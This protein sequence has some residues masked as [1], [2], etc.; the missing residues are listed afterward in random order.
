MQRHAGVM[1]VSPKE[2]RFHKP[3]SGGS[4]AERNIEIDICRGDKFI[5]GDEF[6]GLVRHG[7]RAPGPITTP[8]APSERKCTRSQPP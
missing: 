8:F 3:G 2:L 4:M 5:D 6:I 7:Q 1:Q